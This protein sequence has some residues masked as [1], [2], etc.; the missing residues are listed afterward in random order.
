[1]KNQGFTLIELLVV[2]AI[3]GLLA[4]LSVVQFSSARE[5]ARISKG[6]ALEGQILRSVGDDVTARWDFDECSGTTVSDQ[7]G[8]GRNIS[9]VAGTSFST[10]T[11]QK[12]GCSLAFNGSVNI[13]TASVSPVITSLTMSGWI[14]LPSTALHGAV[15]AIGTGYLD[16]FGFGVGGTQLDNN[17]NHFIVV[18]GNVGWY[19]TDVSIGTGWHFLAI[20]RNSTK[21][22]CYLDGSLVYTFS[23]GMVAPAASTYVGGLGSY[24]GSN[25]SNGVNIDDVRIFNRSLSA[26]EIHQYYV[27]GIS[28]HA[29]G[30]AGPEYF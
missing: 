23:G 22:T 6:Q 10:D 19:N 20:E 28:E 18:A 12:N 15:V 9:L 21:T 8:Y 16:G 7:S 14:Y 3:I 11:P 13:S 5:K 17:G 1:M 29:P 24:A 2:I 26:Q 25:L 4:T 30:S 27:E